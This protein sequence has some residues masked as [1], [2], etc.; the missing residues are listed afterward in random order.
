MK[1]GQR[2]F[3]PLHVPA[4][5]GKFRIRSGGPELWLAFLRLVCNLP[6]NHAHK[7]IHIRVFVRS[8]I[9]RSLRACS[10]LAVVEFEFPTPGAGNYKSWQSLD[11]RQ[12]SSIVSG[13]KEN[14]SLTLLH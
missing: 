1:L 6:E 12:V 11:S 2:G 5:H 14:K 3:D 9:G 10:N 13:Q 7:G 4:H 8:N